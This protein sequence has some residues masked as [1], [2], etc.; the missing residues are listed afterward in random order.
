MYR[1]VWFYDYVNGELKALIIRP[2]SKEIEVR[3]LS[4][5]EKIAHWLR[6]I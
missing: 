2:D 3:D 5:W 4:W 6:I 1:P